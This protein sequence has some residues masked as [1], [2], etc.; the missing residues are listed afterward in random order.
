MH[1]PLI[2]LHHRIRDLVSLNLEEQEQRPDCSMVYYIP[3][4]ITAKNDER[5]C[6]EE[7]LNK[8]NI[9]CMFSYVSHLSLYI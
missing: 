6:T 3:T 1:V 8:R 5:R 7:E 9:E 2:I 4:T